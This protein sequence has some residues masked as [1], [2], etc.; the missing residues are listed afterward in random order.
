MNQYYFAILFLF[1][2]M[3]LVTICFKD[4]KTPKITRLKEINFRSIF[5]VSIS[6][7]ILIYGII[8]GKI[9]DWFN[10]N[11]FTFLMT[12]GILLSGVFVYNQCTSRKPYISF[13]PL[14]N[15]KSVIG[16]IFMFICVVRYMETAKGG[17]SDAEGWELVKVNNFGILVMSDIWVWLWYVCGGYG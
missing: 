2:T 3:V 11:I 8:Y 6:Y 4:A 10:S 9:L 1:I 7:L 16:Y 13:R 14:R 15:M 17:F 12:A 5:L